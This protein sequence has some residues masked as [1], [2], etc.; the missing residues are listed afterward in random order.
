MCVTGKLLYVCMSLGLYPM[1][2]SVVFK[3]G[4]VMEHWLEVGI[5]EGMWFLRCSKS[6]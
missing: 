4:A 2:T 6:K 3:M 1:K 5:N